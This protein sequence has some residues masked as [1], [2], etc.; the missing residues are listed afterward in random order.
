MQHDE[1]VQEGA[2]VFRRAGV[3]LYAKLAVPQRQCAGTVDQT[4]T[5][6]QG[7]VPFQHETAGLER[8]L[9]QLRP[10][11]PALCA[12]RGPQQHSTGAQQIQEVRITPN[13]CQ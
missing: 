1:T 12:Q 9:P 11:Y 10:R 2:H 7:T 13:M 4:G 6:G 5:Q 8:L 3:F